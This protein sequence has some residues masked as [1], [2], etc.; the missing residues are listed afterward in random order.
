MSNEKVKTGNNDATGRICHRPGNHCGSTAIRDLLE[1]HGILLSEAMCFGLGGGLGVTYFK[2]PHEKLP[3]IVH[4]RSMNYE[5]RVFDNLDIP[6]GWRTFQDMTE[7][8]DDLREHLLNGIPAL[9]LTNI[10]HL[11]Y[12]ETDTEFPGHAIIAW[13]MDE[14][15][16]TV[17]VTDTEREALIAVPEEAIARARFS[18]LPPFVH[19][20]SVFSPAG[21]TLK[22]ALPEAMAIAIKENAQRLMSHPEDGL[23]SLERWKSDIGEWCGHENWQWIFRFAYQ[24]IEKRGTGGGGFRKMYAGFLHEAEEFLTPVKEHQ[25]VGKMQHAAHTWTQYA[26]VFK[27]QSVNKSP[28][29]DELT[30]SLDEVIQAEKAYLA[31]AEKAFL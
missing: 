16:Q 7:A 10:R 8:A 18:K 5:Q 20:G 3:Y 26:L 22:R 19:Y 25:L 23:A 1:F 14:K 21:L 13:R 29:I 15:T 24:V 12:F 2:A 31:A 27:Q 17:F 6:F 9:L 30:H 28:D 11:P 4:V